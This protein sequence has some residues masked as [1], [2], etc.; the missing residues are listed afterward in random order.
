[1]YFHGRCVS[2]SS[3]EAPRALPLEVGRASEP[4]PGPWW[5]TAPP[6]LPESRVAIRAASLVILTVSSSPA[7]HPSLVCP[8]LVTSAATV[9]ARDVM[10]ADLTH[11]FPP[12][13]PRGQ[14]LLTWPCGAPRLAGACVL[15]CSPA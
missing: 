14:R 9:K 11:W 15:S 2:P 5:P 13:C 3:A 10:P 6:P 1:M 4:G 8:L 12:F 7:S